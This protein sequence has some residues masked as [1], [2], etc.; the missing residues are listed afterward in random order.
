VAIVS[1][2]SVDLAYDER[3]EGPP[4]LLVHGLASDA[5]A[6]KPVA[7]ALSERTR[8]ISYDRRGYGDSTAP[9]PYT[10]TTVVEQAVDAAAL[11]RELDAEG[12]L[13]IGEDLGALVCLDLLVR[14]PGLLS[15]AVLVDTP[16]FAFVPSA[17]EA[18]GAERVALEEAMRDGGPEAAVLAWLGD[19]GDAARRERAAARP[20]AFFADYA[21]L[22]SW[23]VT[24]RELRGIAVPV[25][26]VDTPAAPAHVRE[27]GD[28]LA[29]LVPGARR[30]GDG[31]AAAAAS[32]LL[33]A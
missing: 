2:G 22:T 21:G 3:G 23:P 6:W 28:R 9:E 8:C 20:L 19:R 7:D 1:L 26:I 25:S 31:D 27:A 24:R 5:R 29:E 4:V 15:A 14:R 12:A 30:R 17:T 16:L 32:E 13:A 10:G 33:A 11:L 18:L